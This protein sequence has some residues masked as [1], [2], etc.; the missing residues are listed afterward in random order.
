MSDSEEFSRRGRIRP[1]SPAAKARLAQALRENLQRRKAQARGQD[2]A[3]EKAPQ[4]EE[5]THKSGDKSRGRG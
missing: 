4:E 2:E 1:S 3:P 5:P